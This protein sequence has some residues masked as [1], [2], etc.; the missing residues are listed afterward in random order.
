MKNPARW[1]VIIGAGILVGIILLLAVALLVSNLVF[2]QRPGFD[3]GYLDRI[4]RD[5]ETD[6]ERIY[7]TGTSRSGPPISATM[8]GMHRM[9]PGSMACANCHGAD[10]QGGQVTMMMT[11]VNAPDIRY[12]ALTE[13]EHDHDDDQAEEEHPPYTDETI[14]RAITQ[15]VDPADEPLSWVMPRWDMSEEQL[16]EVVEYLKTLDKQGHN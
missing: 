13:P 8:P 3:I 7:F 9:G 1:L 10:G 5:F 11:T 6:G 2:P 12:S 15:G 16:N 14:K 4:F